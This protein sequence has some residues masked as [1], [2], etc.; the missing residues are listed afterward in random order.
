MITTLLSS[1]VFSCIMY[2]SYVKSK[3]Q[4]ICGSFEVMNF[5]S[6]CGTEVSLQKV[7]ELPLKHFRVSLLS[8]SQT[9][10][11]NSNK[12]QNELVGVLAWPCIMQRL[13][14][15]IYFKE[16]ICFEEE[17]HT[18]SRWPCL[19]HLADG[20][21]CKASEI[22]FPQFIVHTTVGFAEQVLCHQ[23]VQVT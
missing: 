22:T 6:N 23:P 2:Y 14:I 3:R 9:F 17:F 5:F 19:P 16:F 12:K 18:V 20:F 11:C 21:L 4:P 1:Q 8:Q 13:T 10:K 7:I 15:I